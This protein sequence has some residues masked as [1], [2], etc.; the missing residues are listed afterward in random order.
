MHYVFARGTWY[1]QHHDRWLV[2][3][4]PIGVVIPFLPPFATFTWIGGAPYYYANN[5][6]YSRCAEGYTVVQAPQVQTQIP[7]ST[8]TA[9][10]PPEVVELGQAPTMTLTQA[11]EPQLFVYP[12]LGQSADQQDRDRA[13]C[14]EW[15]AAQTGVTSL[16]DSNTLRAMSACMDGRGYTIK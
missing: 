14:G 12:R 1:R 11:P 2:V 5:V 9:Q 4:A 7:V 16:Q 8:V 15:A 10:A 3:A 13:E 6:F